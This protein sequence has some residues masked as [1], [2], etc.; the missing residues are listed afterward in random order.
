MFG[1]FGKGS[2]IKQ[3]EA[4]LKSEFGLTLDKTPHKESIVENFE[5][6]S[7][8]GQLSP[9]AQTALLYRLVIMNYLGACKIMRD[10]GKNT[11]PSDLVWLTQ[12]SGGSID[13][14]ERARDHVALEAL[15]SQLNMNIFRFFES[16]GIHRG[17]GR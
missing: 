3:A 4:N 13:W 2:G 1:L 17:S 15:T 11:D 10:N 16:F 14:S 8:E 7:K 6:M 5:R 12:L 9:E